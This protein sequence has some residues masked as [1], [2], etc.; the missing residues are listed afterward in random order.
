MVEA[1]AEPLLFLP[2]TILKALSARAARSPASTRL[3][4]RLRVRLL[5]SY[6]VWPQA[7]STS[8]RIARAAAPTAMNHRSA[9]PPGLSATCCSAPVLLASSP[10]PPMAIWS[11]SQAS[12]RKTMP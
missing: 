1:V 6:R 10:P 8:P 9:L 11:A 4:T 12:T 5:P 3:P 2:V 7:A